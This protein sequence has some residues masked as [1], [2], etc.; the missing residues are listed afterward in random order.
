MAEKL[1]LQHE[2]KMV[3]RL[4]SDVV[5]LQRAAES[6]AAGAANLDAELAKA[7]ASAASARAEA[8]AARTRVSAH[9]EEL[10]LSQV[11]QQRLLIIETQRD[12]PC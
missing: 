8:Q 3:A 10:R 2:E 12:Q 5:D 9:S 7:T 4:H 6:R 11:Q 1:A